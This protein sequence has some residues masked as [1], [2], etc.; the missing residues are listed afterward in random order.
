MGDLR[1]LIRRRTFMFALLL[2]VA[3]LIANVVAL[4]DFGKPDNWV[5]NLRIFAPFALVAMASTPAIISGG[6][7]LDLS[8][9]PVTNLINVVLVV[10]LLPTSLGSPGIAI[11]LMLAL[12]AGVGLIN[13]V[14]VSVLRFPPV[15]ATLCTFFVVSGIVLNIAPSPVT[16]AVNWTTQLGGNFG[17]VPGPL[18][19]ILGPAVVWMALR[20]TPFHRLLYA[21]GASDSTAFSAGVNVASVRIVAYAIDGLFAAVA[22][23]ALTV[24]LQTGDATLGTQYTLVAIA[25]VVLG[26][27]PIGGGRG[28]LVG[29]IL[30][31]AV[32]YLLQNLLS[33][34]HVSATWLQ[35]VYGALLVAGVVLGAQITSPRLRAPVRR[36]T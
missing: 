17:P 10:K 26:G 23:I 34:A 19:L 35:V 25:A 18:L 1:G 6:G 30:G 22:G 12:G 21:V 20:L 27:T 9:G 2:S 36:A 32:I 31:A 7:G 4:P 24:F 11:P 28:G 15:I 16:P 13:G 33:E 29:S 14:L 8:V 5:N 3:L